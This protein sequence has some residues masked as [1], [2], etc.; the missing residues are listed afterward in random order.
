MNDKE[1][2]QQE[3][4]LRDWNVFQYKNSCCWILSIQPN[5]LAVPTQ[6]P[7]AQASP[8]LSFALLLSDAAEFE[9][10]W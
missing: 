9:F 3:P 1:I 6:A 5:A 4:Y 7:A 2:S 10:P 8:Q